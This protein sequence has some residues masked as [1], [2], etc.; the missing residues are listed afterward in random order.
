M[1]VCWPGPTASAAMRALCPR[2]D[3]DEA[4]RAEGR[5]RHQVDLAGMGLQ[6][7]AQDAIALEPQPQGRQAFAAVAAPLRA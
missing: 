7:P 1:R 4:D 5:G 2:L 6:P 3:L